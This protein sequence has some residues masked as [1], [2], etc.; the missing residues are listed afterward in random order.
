MR[1]KLWCPTRRY[2][3]P[4][5]ELGRSPMDPCGHLGQGCGQLWAGERR[6]AQGLPGSRCPAI[7]P[8]KSACVSIAASCG[9]LKRF[10]AAAKCSARSPRWKLWQMIWTHCC[11][12]R[13][14]MCWIF[15][16]IHS[17]I[18]NISV[19]YPPFWRDTCGHQPISPV[20]ARCLRDPVAIGRCHRSRSRAGRRVAA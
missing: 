11:G 6:S 12:L 9:R 16:G 4:V 13:K 19:L 15:E 7:T 8:F 3:G 5:A 1:L 17:T 20:P 2:G 18:P 14:R 10:A